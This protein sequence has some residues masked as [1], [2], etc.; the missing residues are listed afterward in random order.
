MCRVVNLKTDANLRFV[1]LLL[2]A[3]PCNTVELS[4]ATMLPMDILLVQQKKPP[5]QAACI[6][7]VE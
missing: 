6:K 2:K 5:L 3:Q 1:A 7:I 4:V